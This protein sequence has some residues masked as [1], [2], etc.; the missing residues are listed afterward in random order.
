[1]IESL[2]SPDYSNIWSG[3]PFVCV[4][5]HPRTT[6]ADV[7]SNSVPTLCNHPLQKLRS[8]GAIA[9]SDE[10]RIASSFA[11]AS[12]QKR[13]KISKWSGGEC[14]AAPQLG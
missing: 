9:Q 3:L 13:T 8:K 11:E 2:D 12:S 14:I 6:I 5:L 4:A 7:T 1:M 10:I